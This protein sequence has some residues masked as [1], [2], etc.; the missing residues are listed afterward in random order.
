MG[1]SPDLSTDLAALEADREMAGLFLTEALEHLVSIESLALQLERTPS[2][3]ALIDAVYRPFH[4][5]KGN[6]YAIG[7]LSV[8]KVAHQAESLI[9]LIRV[10]PRQLGTTEVDAIL[11]TVDRLRTMMDRLTE[12]LNPTVRAEVSERQVRLDSSSVKV[13][14]LRLDSLVDLA[15]ELAILHGM[16]RESCPSL[17]D[18]DQLATRQF[19]KLGRLLSELQRTSLSLRLASL[20]RTFHRIARVVRDVSQACAK[21][22]DLTMSGEAIELDRRIIEQITDPLIHLVRN[23]ID[24]G[25]EDPSARS[26]AGKPERGRL[27]VTASHREAQVLIE[28]ADDGRG[29]DLDKIRV[30]AVAC[31][32]IGE[33]AAL[34]AAEV[35]QLIFVPGF[36][37]AD[38]VTDLSGRGVGLDVVRRNVQAL[39]GRIDTRSERGRGTT[40]ALKLPL[41]MTIV[42][43]VSVLSGGE[44]FVVPTQVLRG[45]WRRRDCEVHEGPGRRRF[46]AIRGTMLPF[47]ELSRLLGG[48]PAE[49]GE[50]DAVV[51]AIEED[52]R[53]AAILVDDVSGS[54]EFVV[55]TLKIHGRVRGFSGGAVLGDG[56]V[57]LIVDANDL[58][59]MLSEALSAAA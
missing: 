7:A 26:A 39:G 17:Q 37:T 32:L 53:R 4:T 20:D 42:R 36:S 59:D 55:K 18:P 54:Q 27:S 23:A 45:A 25:I 16:I 51:L 38:L 9:E 35:S 29:L 30:R 6:A 14:T 3:R 48:C 19:T 8:G 15:G 57:G 13:D 22:I 41:T 44:R 52:G 46:A 33:A 21:P 2:E 10:N 58:F 40:F 56:R 5:I 43:G 1:T 11:E 31:G 12:G 24:H 28:I 34:T 47:I 50:R 49:D